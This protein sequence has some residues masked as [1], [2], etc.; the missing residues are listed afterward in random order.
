[1]P[2]APDQRTTGLEQVLRD[3]A[4]A[5]T[6]V[7]DVV[8][9]VIASHAQLLEIIDGL[10]YEL[11]MVSGEL[12]ALKAGARA[13]PEPAGN[14]MAQASLREAATLAQRAAAILERSHVT[15]VETRV[16]AR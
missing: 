16:A 9:D 8:K 1:M 2:V 10:G 14:R 12:A 5:M 11:S 3:N 7:L 4:D 15:G 6:D 13:T